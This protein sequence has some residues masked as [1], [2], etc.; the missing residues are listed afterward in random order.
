MFFTVHTSPFPQSQPLNRV[1]NWDNRQSYTTGEIPTFELSNK[2]A[3]Y[4]FGTNR[5]GD[6]CVHYVSKNPKA[7]AVIDLLLYQNHYFYVNKTSWSSL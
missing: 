1:T 7:K 5:K 3:I 6:I 2:L 4:V